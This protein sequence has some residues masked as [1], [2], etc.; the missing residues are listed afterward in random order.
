MET[1]EIEQSIASEYKEGASMYSLCRKY[2]TYNKKI[3]KILSNNNVTLRSKKDSLLKSSLD[4]NLTIPLFYEGYSVR[5]LADKFNCSSTTMRNHLK[6]S[7]ITVKLGDTLRVVKEDPFKGNSPSINYWLGF[8]C[9]DGSVEKIG[10]KTKSRLHLGCCDLDSMIQYKN[11]I[12]YPVNICTEARSLS[13]PNHKDFHY[14]K[15]SNESTIETLMSLNITENKSL[16]LNPNI[17]FSWD[18]I[19]GVFDGDGC[20]TYR[21]KGYKSASIGTGSALFANRINEFLNGNGIKSVIYNDRNFYKVTVSTFEGIYRWYSLMY[22]GNEYYMK[23]K[24][25]KF[26]ECINN[27]KRKASKH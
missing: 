22:T 18:F 5:E 11:F 9:A 12:G 24:K 23:R 7:G 3:K 10:T 6:A 27:W 19:R 4:L 14:V 2:N 15:F 8:I 26:E 17:E 21:L 25:I 16:T 13:N 20:I 1:Q